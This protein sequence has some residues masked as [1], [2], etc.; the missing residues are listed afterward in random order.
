MSTQNSPEMDYKIVVV[1]DPGVGKTSIL[2]RYCLGEF[3]PDYGIITIGQD[4]YT[5][6]SI[7]GIKGNFKLRDTYRSEMHVNVLKSYYEG[8]HGI[9]FVY[10]VTTKKTFDGINEWLE[11]ISKTC[12]SNVRYILV[13]NKCDLKD[14]IEVS[15]ME[16]QNF[17]DHNGMLFI[18]SSA[19]ENINIDSIFSMLVNDIQ[20]D[21][22]VS[23]NDT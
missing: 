10:D 23:K 12:A 6:D 11:Y 20:N 21:V 2:R 13:G 19:K 7:N 1:G 3:D 14:E 22:L 15:T 17:A 18:E 4:F 16:G 8:C 9:V 5:K